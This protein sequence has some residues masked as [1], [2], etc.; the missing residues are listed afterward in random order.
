MSQP[1]VY[2]QQVAGKQMTL[3]PLRHILHRRHSAAGAARLMASTMLIV[4]LLIP[5]LTNRSQARAEKL[6][7]QSAIGQADYIWSPVPMGGGGFVTGIVIHP[8]DSSIV[9]IRTDIGGAYRWQADADGGPGHWLPL[10]DHFTFEEFNYYGIES[11]NIDPQNKD[12]VYIAAGK[13]PWAGQGRI[14]KSTDRGNSWQPTGLELAMHG[15]GPARIAGERLAVDPTDSA[16]IYYGSRNDGL[17]KSV[18]GGMT[19]KPVTGLAEKGDKGIGL[20]F[21]SFQRPTGDNDE[22]STLFVGVFG[23]GVF[24]SAD[25]GQSFDGIGGPTGPT[26]IALTDD[27]RF[28]LTAAEGVFVYDGAAGSWTDI[29][30]EKGQKYGALA[31]DPRDSRIVLTAPNKGAQQIPIFRS[32]DGGRTWRRHTAR[33]DKLSITVPWVSSQQFAAAPAALAVDSTNGNKI[34][35]TDWYGVW[36]ADFSTDPPVWHNVIGGI[37]EMVTYTLA[38]PPDGAPLFSG[39]ADNNGFRHRSLRRY[40]MRKMRG[41]GIWDTM[42]IDY[43]EANPAFLVR[44]GYSGHANGVMRGGGGYSVDNGR[45]WKP[46]QKWPFGPAAKIAYSSDNP[47]HLVVIPFGEVPHRTLDRGTTWQ[48]AKGAPDTIINRRWHWNHPLAADR[49]IGSRF[50]LYADGA[51]LR[52]DDGGLTW[53][54]TATLPEDATHF[55]EA[56]PG[57][58]GHVW[59]SLDWKGLFVSQDGGDTFSKVAVVQRARLFSFGKGRSD[60]YGPALYLFGRVGA[61][62]RDYFYRSEDF[63]ITWTRVNTDAN[64]IGNQPNVLRG[65]RQVFGR[66]Y[67]GTNGRG[68]FVGEP[69][70]LATASSQVAAEDGGSMWARLKTWWQ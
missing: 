54:T 2:R 50:Y 9:Y 3:G 29:S 67:V 44:V 59:V 7:E 37:E 25:G 32:V 41:A 51:F 4:A 49:A 33:T 6:V 69:R 43:H 34:W 56:A 13:F 19:W 5:A 48:A 20:T 61:D 53:R 14:F 23:K 39:V 42:G 46:F 62:A 8:M 11:I 63:G 58:A 27:G 70:E 52:S 30:P 60:R 12:V 17:Q 47:F 18:D 28:Y 24:R 36:R 1:P 15:N 68:I 21:V 45:S 64:P 57:L 16:V 40:P 35:M 55:V 26:Q 31:V 66:V 38:T 22:K 10:V 65:D